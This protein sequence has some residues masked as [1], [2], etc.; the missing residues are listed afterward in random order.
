MNKNRFVLIA[1]DI[2]TASYVRH[3]YYYK[4]RYFFNIS[5]ISNTSTNHFSCY[6]IFLF[7]VA[8][9]SVIADKLNYY[10]YLSH[11]RCVHRGA[12]FAQMRTT[13]V[14]KLLPEAWG[15]KKYEIFSVIV[16]IFPPGN[17]HVYS[18]PMQFA[19]GVRKTSKNW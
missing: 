3:A 19:V 6:T 1:D 8:G 11:F 2:S 13:A 14:R 5:Y 17:C 7:Q 12:F 15:K 10:R 9:Y 18:V 4:S 16:K